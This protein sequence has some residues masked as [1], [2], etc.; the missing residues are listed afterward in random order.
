[1]SVSGGEK[2]DDG[3]EAM[4]GNTDGI[5]VSPVKEH[6]VGRSDVMERCT[7]VDGIAAIHTRSEFYTW[8]SELEATRASEA[9]ATYKKHAEMVEE[10]INA[11]NN[12]LKSIDMIVEIFDALKASQRTISSRTDALKEQCDTLV[13]EREKLSNMSRMVEERLDHFNRLETL[14]SLFHAPVSASSDPQSILQGLT[15]LD[16]SLGFTSKHPEYLESAKYHAKFQH[17]QTRALSLV[18]S[19]FEE[20]I[21]T[22][23]AECKIAA[24]VIASEDTDTVGG[25][26]ITLQNVKFRAVAEPRLKELMGGVCR[27]SDSPSY[28]QLLKDCSSIYCTSRFELIRYS[29]FSQIQKFKEDNVIDA[30]KR[31][32]ECIA[33]AAEME[34]QLYQQIFDGISMEQTSLH[35]ANL[36][37]SM[38]ILLT[39]VVEPMIYAQIPSNLDEL[40]DVNAYIHSLMRSTKSRACIFNVPSLHKLVESIETLIFRQA[41]VE[42]MQRG[43]AVLLDVEAMDFLKTVHSPLDVSAC[44]VHSAVDFL[45]V[46]HVVKTLK[47]LYPS[48]VQ[49]DLFVDFIRDVVTDLLAV[50]ESGSNTLIESTGEAHGAIFKLR[51]LSLLMEC[52]DSFTDLTFT[53]AKE[54]Q[55]RGFAQLGRQISSKI[56]SSFSQ[57]SAQPR[58]MR[59]EVQKKLTV[60]REFCMVT[61]SQDVINPLLSFLT[62]ATAAKVSATS[63]GIKSL[64]FG[65]VERV[66]HLSQEVKNAIHGPLCQHVAL[67]YMALPEKEIDTVIR[68]IRENVEDALKQLEN[69][70]REEYTDEERQSIAFPTVEDIQSIVI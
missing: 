7:T 62:K 50:I 38:C 21:S 18:K 51:Q 13:S 56:L 47:K 48:V 28:Q 40:T 53:E 67:L 54:H 33:Q 20:S 15:D 36:F 58:N 52:L 30:L 25:A 9:E 29:L 32:S 10:H 3:E 60:S 14:S 37:D 4:Q 16:L 5:S 31:G 39:A 22:A 70:L 57:K 19:Y 8:F 65:S 27:H 55:R 45:P 24:K 17:L 34:I 12:M 43:E 42:C 2:P 6:V 66:S 49:K 41:K 46:T 59:A 64:A 35:L 11:C 61:C 68:T 23:V 69:I 26:E 44:K 1:M 63:D